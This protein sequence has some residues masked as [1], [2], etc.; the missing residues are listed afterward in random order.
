MLSLVYVSSAT[1]PFSTKQLYDLLAKSRENN[2]R[3]G[4]TGILLYKDG[5]FMQLL[6]GP[7]QAVRDLMDAIQQDSRHQGLIVL[8]QTTVAERSFPEWSMGFCDLDAPETKSIPGYSEFLNSPLT[9]EE[10]G[11]DPQRS[12]KLLLCFKRSMCTV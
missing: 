1:E 4:L 2:A 11:P 9:G 8:S 7:E 12:Q 3:R 10:F 6:E 5:N